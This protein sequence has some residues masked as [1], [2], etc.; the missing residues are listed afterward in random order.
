MIAALLG[1][2]QR[3]FSIYENF[4]IS[5]SSIAEGGSVAACRR[6]QCILGMFIAAPSLMAPRLPFICKHRNLDE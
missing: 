6:N 4:N 5:L 2:R 3:F 1:K